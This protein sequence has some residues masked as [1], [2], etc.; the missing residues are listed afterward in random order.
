MACFALIALIARKHWS[1]STLRE[2]SVHPKCGQEK[3][4]QRLTFWVRRPPGGVGVLHAKGWW[5]KSSCPP[6]KVCFSLSLEGRNLGCPR[7]FARMSRTSG[8]SKSL[9][10]KLVPIFRPLN[11]P[12]PPPKKNTHKNKFQE[13][14]KDLEVEGSR[15]CLS[16]GTPLF[17]VT[18]S[19]QST[20]LTVFRCK[21]RG[22]Y[23]L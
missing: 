16:S 4:A 5:S 6:S 14:T 11:S 10:K 12:P 7:N 13:R 21:Q 8:G 23:D 1:D 15:G 2:L 9:S 17:M 20:C 19:S 18:K 3:R 22:A